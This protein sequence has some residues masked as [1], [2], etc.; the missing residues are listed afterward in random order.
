MTDLNAYEAALEEAM[1]M[2]EQGQEMNR[3][4]FDELIAQ[5]GEPVPADAVDLSEDDPRRVG[6]RA[7]L[8]RANEL[9]RSAAIGH[10]QMDEINSLLAPLMGRKSA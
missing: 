8:A 1:A 4:R 10:G 9:E 5:L 6:A 7:L 2:L 3:A